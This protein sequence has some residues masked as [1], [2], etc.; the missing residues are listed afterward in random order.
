MVSPKAIAALV[1]Q[2]RPPLECLNKDAKIEWMLEQAASIAMMATM[3]E[4]TQPVRK[5]IG[6]F[7]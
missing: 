4:I 3:N 2:M 1:M 6:G 5:S 7:W